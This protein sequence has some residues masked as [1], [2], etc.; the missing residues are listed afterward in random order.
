V[1]LTG[2]PEIPDQMVLGRELRHHANL[3]AHA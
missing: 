3:E 1:R 2:W